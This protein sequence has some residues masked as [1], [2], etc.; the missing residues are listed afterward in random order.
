MYLLTP[1]CARKSSTF[2]TFLCGTHIIP[3]GCDGLNYSNKMDVLD[4]IIETLKEHEKT[5]DE[6]AYRLEN[7]LNAKSPLRPPQNENELE[8]WR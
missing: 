1:L 7:S 3:L 8:S 6:L 2:I 5:L 4:L